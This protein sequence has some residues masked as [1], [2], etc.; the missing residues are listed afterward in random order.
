MPI[1]SDFCGGRKGKGGEGKITHS[2]FREILSQGDDHLTKST[3]KEPTSLLP[4]QKACIRTI[5]F[6]TN[7]VDGFYRMG[8]DGSDGFMRRMLRRG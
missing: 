2:F 4:L 6:K 8:S 3:Q 7:L 5:E 1:H